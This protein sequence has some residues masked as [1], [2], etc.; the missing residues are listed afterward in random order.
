[1]IQYVS[2]I[3]REVLKR[4]KLFIVVSKLAKIEFH[5]HK[6]IHVCIFYIL[7]SNL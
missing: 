6:E 7:I 5:T 3:S 2:V 4:S 1:M